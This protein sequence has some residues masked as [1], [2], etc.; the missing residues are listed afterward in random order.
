MSD[1]YILLVLGNWETVRFRSLLL[2]G[3]PFLAYTLWCASVSVSTVL[4]V[5]TVPNT[6]IFSNTIHN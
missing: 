3:L 5:Y 4:Q 6:I 1:C 2:L